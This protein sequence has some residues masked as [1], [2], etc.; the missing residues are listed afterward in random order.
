MGIW[1][2]FK[3]CLMKAT[4]ILPVFSEHAAKRFCWRRTQPF[5]GCLE[6]SQRYERYHWPR[7]VRIETAEKL[8]RHPLKLGQEKTLQTWVE[9][10]KGTFGISWRGNLRKRSW[11]AGENQCYEYLESRNGP[12]EIKQSEVIVS[13]VSNA[14]NF[15]PL[16][17]PG[18]YGARSGSLSPDNAAC[19]SA[20]GQT[21]RGPWRELI[22]LF[23]VCEFETPACMVLQCHVMYGLLNLPCKTEGGRRPCFEASIQF[24]GFTPHPLCAYANLFTVRDWMSSAHSTHE[25]SQP[26]LFHHLLYWT[27]SLRRKKQGTRANDV[28]RT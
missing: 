23:S 28:V 21:Q 12:T 4:L 1:A 6:Q 27:C 8:M 16:S 19:G 2:N 5:W 3:A 10:K 25:S 22:G 18:R 13:L 26:L 7:T 15:I 20:N 14:S 24:E 17:H 11:F 9:Q